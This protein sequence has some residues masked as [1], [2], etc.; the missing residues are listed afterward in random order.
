MSRRRAR[1]IHAQA[2][3][4]AL[5][6]RGRR[7]DCLRLL[8]LKVGDFCFDLRSE[9]VRGAAQFSE[10]LPGL[11]S[12]LR[13]LLWPKENERQEEQEDGVGKTHGHIIDARGQ[14]RQCVERRQ[15]VFNSAGVRIQQS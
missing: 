3:K 8:N 1:R 13:Q 12:H 6:R 7:Q 2:G 5:R 10:K 15:P 14:M 4:G 9:L 11:T